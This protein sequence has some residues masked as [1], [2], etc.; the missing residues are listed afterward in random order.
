VTFQLVSHKSLYE[1]HDLNI[2]ESVQYVPSTANIQHIFNRRRS[3]PQPNSAMDHPP[4]DLEAS[5]EQS[6]DDEEEPQMGLSTTIALL[7]IVT[8]VIGVVTSFLLNSID[9]LTS[10]GPIGKGFVGLII[11]PVA[12]NIV[13]YA[14]HAISSAEDKLDHSMNIAVGSSIQMALFVIPFMVVLGWILGKPLTLLFD[15]FLSIVLFLTVYAVSRMLQYGTSNWLKGMTLICM[16]IIVAF[17]IW[18]YP[19]SDPAGVFASC[20]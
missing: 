1:G 2:S 11:S 4:M 9:N 18:Y 20:T 10:N 7:G 6:D 16:Y 15:P 12:G 8:V 3:S 13:E 19:V 14:E 17:T 5:L